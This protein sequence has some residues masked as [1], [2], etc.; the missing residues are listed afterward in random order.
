[1]TE[2]ELRTIV[3]V[4][5]EKG[6]IET[7]ERNRSI[8]CLIWM[9]PGCRRH[10]GTSRNMTFIDIDA[11]YEELMEKIPQDPLYPFSSLSGQQG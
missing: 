1:M 3:A 6:G 4:G 2:D 7:D 11:S 8:M 5:H 10:Y 9:I